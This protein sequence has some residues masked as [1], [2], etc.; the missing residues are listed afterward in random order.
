MRTKCYVT[1][2]PTVRVSQSFQKNA[3][4]RGNGVALLGRKQDM[5]VM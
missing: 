4:R 3:Q 5:K 1:T 2:I